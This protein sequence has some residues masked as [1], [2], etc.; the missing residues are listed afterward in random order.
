MNKIVIIGGGASGLAA[1][2][3]AARCG[4][5]VTISEKNDRVGKKLLSTGNGRCNF[6]NINASFK[7]YNTDFVRPVM[8]RFPPERTI[9]FFKGLGVI[10]KIEA[11]GRVYPN[12]CQA[13]AVLDVLRLEA[14]R[15]G[16]FVKTEFDA[17][18]VQKKGNGFEIFSR[19]NEKIYADKIIFAAGGKAAPKT[20]SNGSVYP[21][22]E[23][24]GHRITLIKPSLVQIKTEKSIGGVRQYGRVFLSDGKERTGE[25]QFNNYGISGI[26][27][28]G[29]SKYISAADMVYIDLLPD[30]TEKEV[31][32]ILQAR[33]VQM[34][35]TYLVGILNKNL[36]HL[37]LKDCKIVPLSR[38]SDSLS[39][40]EIRK[41]AAKI[42]CWGFTVTGVMSWDNAQ[43]TSGGVC[44]DDINPETLESK[45]VKNVYIT[46]ELLDVDGDCGGYNLQWAWASGYVAGKEAANV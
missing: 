45:L 10:P 20:G 15:L 42:K 31:L 26:P 35:E 12:S 33:P 27:V 6:T 17:V 1:A 3:S 24:L 25:I 46:G 44:T 23:S 29:L 2:I 9:D 18:R 19:K 36:A 8:D 7:D 38:R 30:Y 28:F 32:E 16:V 21:L 22:L 39:E 34:L 41:I 11:E 14:D 5:F 13:S 37:L 43:V 40:S 4:A